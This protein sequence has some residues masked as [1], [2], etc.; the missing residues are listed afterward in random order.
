METK[1]RPS[2]THKLVWCNGWRSKTGERLHGARLCPL[3]DREVDPAPA[4]V[5]F[6]LRPR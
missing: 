4:S 2:A 1:P 3:H 6:E 5:S